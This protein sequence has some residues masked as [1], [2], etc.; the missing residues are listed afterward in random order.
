MELTK[1]DM[2]YRIVI[3]RNPT[4]TSSG[5]IAINA[6]RIAPALKNFARGAFTR[7]FANKNTEYPQEV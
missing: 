1:R 6:K 2:A 3:T 4:I 7:T 5:T